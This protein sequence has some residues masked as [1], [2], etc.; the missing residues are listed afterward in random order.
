MDTLALITAGLAKLKTAFGLSDVIWPFRRKPRLER[1]SGLCGGGNCN[2]SAQCSKP[3]LQRPPARSCAWKTPVALETYEALWWE[4][5]SNR[6]CEAEEERP[7]RRGFLL[8]TLRMLSHVC[9]RCLDTP[10]R[11]TSSRIRWAQPCGSKVP[12]LVPVAI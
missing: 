5:S 9:Q 11:H 6:S 12:L 4:R 1:P 2:L 8:F 10:S 3:T 7:S